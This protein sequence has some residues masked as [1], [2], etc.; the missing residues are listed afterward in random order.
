MDYFS[1]Y[2]DDMTLESIEE[3]T[4]GLAMDI[5]ARCALVIM[6][7]ISVNLVCFMGAIVLA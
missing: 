7:L 1:T 3:V 6:A 4:L 2:T 5:Q